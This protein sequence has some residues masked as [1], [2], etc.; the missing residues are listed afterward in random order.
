MDGG[1]L[2]LDGEDERGA[3]AGDAL[4]AHVATHESAEAL[5]DREAEAGAA[6]F[7]GGGGVDLREGFEEAVE[8]VGGD[9]DAGVAD[10]ELEAEPGRIVGE[11]VGEAEGGGGEVGAADF[12]GDAAAG[13]T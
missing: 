7:A 2:A 10:G 9:A 12:D 11:T 8:A 3:L 13:G 5:A 6:V 4:D 1:G